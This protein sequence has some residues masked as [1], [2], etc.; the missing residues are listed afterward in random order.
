MNV[1]I[2]EREFILIN[3]MTNIKYNSEK[4]SKICKFVNITNE[5]E[6]RYVRIAIYCL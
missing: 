2:N 1:V 3:R 4:K 5:T 6:L